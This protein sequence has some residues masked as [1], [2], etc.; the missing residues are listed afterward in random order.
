MKLLLRNDLWLHAWFGLL[1]GMAYLAKTSVE[2]LVLGWFAVS[3]MRFLGG[4]FQKDDPM[5]ERDWN[6][7]NHFIGLI[8]FAFAW[9]AVT[10]PRYMAAQERW[11]DARF[12]Y[13][14]AWMWMDKYDDCFAWMGAHGTKAALES[15]P[16]S[17]RPSLMNYYQTHGIDAMKQRLVKGTTEK[18]TRW[19]SPKIVK[20]KSGTSFSGWRVLL[21]RRWVL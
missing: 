8:V 13:P 5:A 3:G 10:A 15:I 21:D 2:P 9:L 4:L 11:G 16:S 20:M 14:G 6:G 17:Q 7:R 12:S 1:G 19:L 18:V